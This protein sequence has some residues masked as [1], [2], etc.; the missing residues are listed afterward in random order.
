MKRYFEYSNEEL[1]KMTDDEVNQLIELECMFLGIDFVDFPPELKKMEEIPDPDKKVYEFFGI[2]FLD[3]DEAYELMEFISTCKSITEIDYDYTIG[4][5]YK[6][7]KSVKKPVRI[8]QVDCY[9]NEAIKDLREKIRIN[10]E[11]EEYNKSLLEAYNE[12]RRGYVEVVDKVNTAIIEAI[13]QENVFSHAKYIFE[14]YLFMTNGD[15]EIAK[16][17]FK[18]TEYSFLLNRI[19]EEVKYNV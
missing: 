11:N 16:S 5:K 13:E 18:E 10:K 3:I 17:F 9:A 8:E 1:S 7:M 14:K 12:K 15:I 19:L 6:Y 2:Y 4:S